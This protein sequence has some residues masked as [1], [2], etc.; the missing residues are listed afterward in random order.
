MI[1]SDTKI[2]SDPIFVWDLVTSTRDKG[3]SLS[4]LNT[5]D[6]SLV[7][8]RVVYCTDAL[9]VHHLLPP[10]PL[11]H[12][13]GNQHSWA[14][15]WWWGHYWRRWYWEQQFRCHL[16]RPAC[17]GE[18]G[19][20]TWNKI[21]DWAVATSAE[22]TAGFDQT[23]KLSLWVPQ[24]KFWPVTGSSRAYAIF[25]PNPNLKQLTNPKIPQNYQS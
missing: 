24:A 23:W 18:E 13:P 21:L 25:R 1:F 6:S 4:K 20:L 17:S 14:S 7:D 10:P 8:S 19:K 12:H 5:L 3:Q 15:G 11:L 16:L 22:A 9:F 2:F